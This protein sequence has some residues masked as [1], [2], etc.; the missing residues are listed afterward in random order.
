M[1]MA[2]VLLRRNTVVAVHWMAV[3]IILGER[4]PYFTTRKKKREETNKT[5]QKIQQIMLDKQR[6]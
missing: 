1:C 4:C 6:C 2:L 3:S 5:E